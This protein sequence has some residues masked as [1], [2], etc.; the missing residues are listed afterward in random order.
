MVRHPSRGRAAKGVAAMMCAGEADEVP[1]RQ[2][3]FLARRRLKRRSVAEN[4]EGSRR[5]AIDFTQGGG[6]SK[7]R[8]LKMAVVN[9]RVT[10]TNQ[11]QS[12]RSWLKCIHNAN[13]S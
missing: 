11:E 13:S 9:E 7:R 4:P 6:I 2:Q 8:F 1:K 12:I 10:R 3:I 5:A